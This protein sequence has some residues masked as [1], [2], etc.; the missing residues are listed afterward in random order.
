[1]NKKETLTIL[2]NVSGCLKPGEMAALMGPSGSGKSTLLDILAGRKTVGEISGGIK[3]GGETPSTMFLRRYTGYVEQFDTLL[4]ILT[5]EEMMKYT[6]DLKRPTTEPASQK[7]AA[8]EEILE[9][10]ALKTCRNVRIGSPLARG[11]SGGQAK[12]VNIGIALITNPRILFLDEPTSG[13]DSYTSNEVMTVVKSLADHGITVCATI[14][15]P[16]PYC[17]SLFD[18]LLLLLRGQVAYFGPCGAPALDYFHKTVPNL[19][20]HKEGENEA[21]WIVDLTTQ[22]DRQGKASEFADLFSQSQNKLDGDYLIEQQLSLSSE[23]DE[24]TKK[25]LAVK[26]ETVTPFWYGLK[27]L[28]KY[29]TTKNYRNPEFLGPRVGDKLIFSILLFTLYWGKGNIL[30]AD[31]VINISGILFMWV[32]L[33]AFG[34]ASYIPAIVLERALFVRERNDG[35]YRVITYLCAKMLEELGIAFIV[36]LVFSNVVWYPL[37]FQGLWVIFWLVYFCTLSIGIVV[38]Y[39]VAAISPNM[40]VANAALPAYIVTLIFFSGFLL[41]YEQIPVWWKWYSYI[42]FLKY[43][44]GA[45]MKNQFNGDR[46]IPFLYDSQ[47]NT[48]LTVLEYYSLDG[49]NMWAWFGFEICFFMVFFLFAF[50]ALRYINHTKR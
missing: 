15:S 43:A 29:R 22:A 50:L 33:P 2:N 49:I 42:D 35:L 46:D 31:N 26:R 6:A 20:A 39:F 45:L 37:K 1:M 34:A 47:T 48:T 12:R 8:V 5:V 24:A 9:L 17:F 36:S 32:N 27:T 19:A 14:H 21:E 23:L 13:L 41:R 40:D 18:R 44:W 16:T 3:F 7:A 28:L 11:I 30:T 4:D 25:E 38:A 10:L